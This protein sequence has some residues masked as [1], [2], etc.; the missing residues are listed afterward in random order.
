M[1][2]YVQA[3]MLAAESA[4]GPVGLGLKFEHLDIVS[5]GRRDRGRGAAFLDEQRPGVQVGQI[6]FIFV[7]RIR[8][9]QWSRRCAGSNGNK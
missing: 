8:R 4:G 6:E 7:L 3:G 1:S 9:V 5:P 2:G